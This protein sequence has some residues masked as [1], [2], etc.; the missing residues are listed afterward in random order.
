MRGLNVRKIAIT[1][2]LAF[3]ALTGFSSAAMAG[4]EGATCAIS[5]GGGGDC[6]DPETCVC[7]IPSING[8]KPM[9]CLM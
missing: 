9:I 4:C 3:A 2:V 7:L 1:A 5:V 6:V 8:S